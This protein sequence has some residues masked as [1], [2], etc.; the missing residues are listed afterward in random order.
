MCIRDSERPSCVH[1]RDRLCAHKRSLVC[2][3]ETL[4]C[5]HTRFLVCTQEISCAHTRD[6]LCAH[7]RSPVCTQDG[8]S[9]AARR[10]PAHRQSA[11]Q[12]VARL[13]ALPG[14]QVGR[15]QVGPGWIIR[16]V[17]RL[18]SPGWR[19]VDFNYP[20]CV[21]SLIPE[22]PYFS[23]ER[24]DPYQWSDPHLFE[25]LCVVSFCWYSPLT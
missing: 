6:L 22:R 17:A 16:Q 18:A 25:N 12:Q 9:G 24:S 11:R 5:A 23:I 1:T 2:T 10:Q 13:R 19:Q 3:Q 15:R 7:K 14:C 8:T 20:V 4:L 21:Q